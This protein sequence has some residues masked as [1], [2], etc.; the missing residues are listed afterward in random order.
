VNA[1][2]I[3]AL[4]R[5][6]DRMDYYRLLR[7]QRDAPPRDLRA[8][9]RKMRREFHPDKFLS[10]AGE[11]RHAIDRVATR[12]T[13]AYL[14]LRDPVR[15]KAYDRELEAGGL[16][17]SSAAEE[18]TRE[19]EAAAG[20]RTANGKKFFGLSRD[21]EAIGDLVKAV[22]HMKMAMTFERDNP[23]FKERLEELQSRIPKAENKHA[24]R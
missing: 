12:V 9:Y 7:V 22:A 5:L 16:R 23:H 14:V 19:D 21:A 11:V 10:E 1:A 17:Y 2:E 8:A 24:I 6:L 4:G 3:R 20:G 13:E 15:R 18:S